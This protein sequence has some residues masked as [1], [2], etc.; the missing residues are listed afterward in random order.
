[1]ISPS[2]RSYIAEHAYVPEH[3]PDYVTAISLTEPFL[4]GDFVSHQ[5]WLIVLCS[6]PGNGKVRRIVLISPVMI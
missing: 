4:T 2:E 3:L 6:R 5:P 1:M